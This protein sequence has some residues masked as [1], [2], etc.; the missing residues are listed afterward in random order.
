MM[1]KKIIQTLFHVFG[2]T[3]SDEEPGL[4]VVINELTEDDNKDDVHSTLQFGSK[5]S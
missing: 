1:M 2:T 3:L 4:Q 5:N